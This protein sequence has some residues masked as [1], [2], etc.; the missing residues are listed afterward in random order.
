MLD[1]P[2]GDWEAWLPVVSLTYNTRVHASTKASPFFLTF[3][4]DP[5]LPNFDLDTQERRLYGESWAADAHER[6]QIAYKLAKENMERAQEVGKEIHGRK[7]RGD[8]VR[9]QVGD[10]VY[11][12]FPPTVFAHLKNKK[13]I[14]PWV[15]HTVT[16]IVTPTTYVVKPIEEG[17]DRRKQTSVVHVNRMK[18]CREGR[19]APSEGEAETQAESEEAPEQES[20]EEEE[21][22]GPPGVEVEMRVARPDEQEERQEDN[23]GEP[24]QQ[25]IAPQPEVQERPRT[26]QQVRANPNLG[27]NVVLT[28]PRRPIEYKVYTRRQP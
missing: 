12:H 27:G 11:V 6:M 14:R 2:D 4:R 20:Q 21:T 25:D 22:A 10:K 1:N 18:A 5:N 3:L 19:R 24:V 23:E 13:F 17:A 26:R 7:L 16:R 28:P 8:E 15:K 9:F